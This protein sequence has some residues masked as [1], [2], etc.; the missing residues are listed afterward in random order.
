MHAIIINVYS[1]I[2]YYACDYKYSL[3]DY[4]TCNYNMFTMHVVIMN[5][6]M[7]TIQCITIQGGFYVESFT[8]MLP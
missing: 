2:A 7:Y 5:V 1:I 8:K 3:Y 6:C 4:C